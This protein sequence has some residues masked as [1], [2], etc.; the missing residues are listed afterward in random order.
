MSLVEELEV[1]LRQHYPSHY[2]H[3]LDIPAFEASGGIFLVCINGDV[4]IGCLGL[5][6]LKSGA[7]ELKRMFVRPDFRGLGAAK[8]MLLEME[9]LASAEGYQ[10][11]VLETGNQ[12]TTAIDLYQAN[13]YRSIAPYNKASDGP[14]SVCFC[15]MLDSSPDTNI[16]T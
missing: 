15:K 8:T 9:R 4:P 13:G 5:R 1:E 7:A 6:P 2:I 12:Q 10:Q 3:E 11:I 16:T 14:A